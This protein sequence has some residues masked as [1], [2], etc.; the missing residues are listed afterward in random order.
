M[1]NETMFLLHDAALHDR[2]DTR[3]IRGG[4][5]RSKR[6]T[7]PAEPHAR[8]IISP[9]ARVAIGYAIGRYPSRQRKPTTTWR[10]SIADARTANPDAST[11]GDRLFLRDFAT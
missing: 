10:A 3:R 8:N 1:Q 2:R 6:G 9:V 4:V 11:C 5:A 7:R